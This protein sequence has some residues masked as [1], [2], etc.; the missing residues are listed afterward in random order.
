MVKKWSQVQILTLPLSN[1]V[2]LGKFYGALYLHLPGLSLF[3]WKT[4]MHIQFIVL[5]QILNEVIYAERLA[6][7]LAGGL[8]SP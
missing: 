4:G 2:A 5:M 6:Q 8:H 7:H 3:I 1:R